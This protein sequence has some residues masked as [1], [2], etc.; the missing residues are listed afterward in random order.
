MEDNP[1]AKKAKGL[2][3]KSSEKMVGN[4]LADIDSKIQRFD[5]HRGYDARS[6]G[7]K[8]QRVA[9]DFSFYSPSAYG[10][11]EVK[12]VAHATRLPYKNFELSQVAKA[13]KRELAG[14]TVIVLIHSTASDLWYPHRISFFQH[15]TGT[16]YASW[17]F[18]EVPAYSS[19]TAALDPIIQP[20]L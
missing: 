2:Q 12:E 15:R 10:I 1:F 16:T 20:L 4:Y 8:F 17:I 5:W 6:A 11:I 9:G 3:G 19:A 14:G 18:S 13:A 7:G